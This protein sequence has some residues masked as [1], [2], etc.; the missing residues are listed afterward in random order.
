MKKLIVSTAL[1]V[2]LICSLDAQTEFTY[3][4][5]FDPNPD[6]PNIADKAANIWSIGNYLYL[7]NGFYNN[8]GERTQQ[9]IKIDATTKI[10]EKIITLDSPFNNIGLSERGGYCLT[11]DGF[12]LVTGEWYSDSLSVMQMFLAKYDA[13][14]ELQWINYFPGL[15]TRN[16]FADAVA[17]TTAG[18][19]MVY[20]TQRTSVNPT[21]SSTRILTTD[22]SG[23][24]LFTKIIPDP[25]L[26]VRGYGSLVNTDDGNLLLTSWVYDIQN[27]PETP[28]NVIVHKIDNQ[29]NALWNRFFNFSFFDDQQPM[30]AAVPGGGGAVM[31]C[32]DTSWYDLVTVDHNFNLMHGFDTD[33]NLLW[34]TE[35]HEPT[36]WRSAG[37]LISA[38]N[39]DLLGSGFVQPAVDNT[40]GRAWLFRASPQGEIL[41]ERYYSDSLLRPWSPQL[42][43][44]DM[45]EMEDGRI[46]ATGIAY[47]KNDQGW[48]NPNILL[49]VFDE[50]GCLEP[51]CDQSNYY[52]TTSLEPLFSLPPLP[53]LQ[54]WPNPAAK[55][56]R[57]QVPESV[58][59]G[60]NDLTLAA[61]DVQGRETYRS[62]VTEAQPSVDASRWPAGAYQLVLLRQGIPVAGG[63]VVV[64]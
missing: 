55:V 11:A 8:D 39:N 48:I 51:G 9:I 64:E 56:F 17:E 14:L 20:Y 32:K 3:F 27:H 47:D 54:V 44:I 24:L 34:E 30:C 2:S 5:T 59:T 46:A 23:N 45:C 7:D 31:W 4:H 19:Y 42:E 61:Y 25:F 50:N 37:R 40:R 1:L 16:V 53:Y 58:W 57:V 15:T 38:A 41:W 28:T 33:G 12:I 35:W 22:T 6:Y 26:Y 63:K 13:D 52:L 43:F 10:V 29:G 18:T 21:I 49:M 60:K 62:T 36:A